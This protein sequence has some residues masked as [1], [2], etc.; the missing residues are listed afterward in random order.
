MRHTALACQGSWARAGPSG[1]IAHRRAVQA[2]AQRRHGPTRGPTAPGHARMALRH[3]PHPPGTLQ[4]QNLTRSWREARPGWEGR[5]ADCQKS[6]K[7]TESWHV[8]Q[9]RPSTMWTGH[10][11]RRALRAVGYSDPTPPA[12]LNG[13]FGVMG[14]AGV[15]GAPPQGVRSSAAHAESRPAAR[16]LRENATRHRHPA[17]GPSNAALGH[18][19]CAARNSW[20]AAWWASGWLKT[21]RPTTRRL[22]GVRERRCRHGT[23]TAERPTRVV[24]RTRRAASRLAARRASSHCGGPTTRAA[25][26]T[27]SSSATRL[28]NQSIGPK[29]MEWSGASRLLRAQRTATAQHTKRHQKSPRDLRNT[30]EAPPEAKSA[31]PRATDKQSAT[32]S[33]GPAT[34]SP[35]PWCLKERAGGGPAAQQAA[36]P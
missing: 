2:R 17:G 26:E 13:R 11:A 23:Y 9:P 16:S 14:P 20:T 7:T 24:S 34:A 31:A 5:P 15:C 28:P 1:G 4:P 22:V 8:W 18:G 25:L 21:T 3:A 35:A 36:V 32:P 6:T 29:P 30:S 33:S 27:T 10:V 12:S 19:P